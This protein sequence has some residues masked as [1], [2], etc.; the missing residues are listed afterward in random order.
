MTSAQAQSLPTTVR[1]RFLA[2]P[3]TD[4]PRDP[5][6]PTPIVDRPLSPLE[7]FDL[8]QGLNQLA[9]E[10]E[11][12]AMANQPETARSLWMREV[13]LRRVL[14]LNTELE[15]LNRV[16][17]WLRDSSAT[18]ELQLLAIR[19][20]QIT[21]GQ[22]VDQAADRERLATI[23]SIYATLGRV[24]SAAALH[25]TLAEAALDRGD[26]NEHLAQLETLA[27]L[28]GDW[29]YFPEAAATYSELVALAGG[30]DEMRFLVGQI[31][32]LE[33][34]Q[35]FEAALL[36]QQHLLNRYRA[37]ESRWIQV[38]ELQYA[39]AQNHQRAGDL[40]RSARHYQVAYTNA[41]EG[42][43][44]E[45]AAQILR[46]L[47][48]L[49]GRVGQWPDVDYLYQQLLA[50]ER[51]ALSAYGLMETFDQIGQ[52]YEQT[53]NPTGALQAYTEGLALAHQLHHRQDHFAEQIQRLTA[54]P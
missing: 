23:A 29:F 12:L 25:R 39:M 38:A 28:Y 22:A 21:P 11:A 30:N 19:V 10:A 32:N 18:Q 41:I 42:E 48:D 14:G 31:E 9:R 5:L 54:M 44:F 52:L 46:A 36:A 51:Q 7:E 26:R 4:Q 2:D 49:Y 24:E 40:E 33:F 3:L 50:V 17:Q 53:G 47:A 35:Q 15:A 16:A 45:M 34:A 1:S 27:R 6:L 43:Q 8:E 20:D 37:D 13:R